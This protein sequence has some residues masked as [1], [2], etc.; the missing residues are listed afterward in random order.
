MN[1][2]TEEQL[3]EAKTH[4]TQAIELL[5]TSNQIHESV[6]QDLIAESD[7]ADAA[8]AL[9]KQAIDEMEKAIESQQEYFAELDKEQL[10]DQ[11]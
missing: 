4:G 7:A 11:K 5:K 2:R 3:K 10:K 6:K 9:N 8:I 1:K